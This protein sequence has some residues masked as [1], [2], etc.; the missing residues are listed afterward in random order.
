[1]NGRI[2]VQMLVLGMNNLNPGSAKW[3]TFIVMLTFV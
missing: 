2:S 3:V 1:M